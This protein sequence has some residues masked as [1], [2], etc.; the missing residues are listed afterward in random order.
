MFICPKC[1]YIL[2]INKIKTKLDDVVN[3]ELIEKFIEY[4]LK[5]KTFE[6]LIEF[7]LDSLLNNN[8]FKKLSESDKKIIKDKYKN[9]Y[10]NAF[11]ICDN[12]GYK[13]QLSNN[14]I[15]Y[16]NNIINDDTFLLSNINTEQK[17]ND[18]T[19]PRT[20]NYICRNKNCKVKESDKEAVYFRISNS[21]QL[22]YICC[23][24]NEIWFN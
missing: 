6:F 5:N 12:C 4:T 17:I 1:D 15:I 8:S 7:N 23:S 18:L 11:F 10:T 3:K 20:K 22:I 19:L 16:K 9:V 13:E 14:T 21:Y 2:N 24:C